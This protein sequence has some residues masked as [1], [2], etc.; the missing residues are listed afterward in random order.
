MKTS[1]TLL[2]TKTKETCFTNK[3]KLPDLY[4]SLNVHYNLICLFWYVFDYPLSADNINPK[5]LTGPVNLSV[6]ITHFGALLAE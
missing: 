6:R 3:D 4:M 5:P 2:D 1:K